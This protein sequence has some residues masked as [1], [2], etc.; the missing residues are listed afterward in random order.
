MFVMAT[1]EQGTNLE[2]RALA[3]AYRMGRIE[4]REYRWR[5]RHVLDELRCRLEVTARRPT[6][7]E[8]QDSVTMADAPMEF[9]GRSIRMRRLF[10]PQI[11][12]LFF[13]TLLAVCGAVALV[14]WFGLLS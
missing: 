8:D 4:D 2:L 10:H 9:R 7:G 12:W 14:L 5:R 13:V 6:L 3:D 1:D 11:R